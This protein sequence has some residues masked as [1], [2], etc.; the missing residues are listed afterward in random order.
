MAAAVRAALIEALPD[1][2]DSGPAELEHATT[3][4]QLHARA[5]ALGLDFHAAVRAVAGSDDTTTTATEEGKTMPGENNTGDG[6]V[7]AFRTALAKGEA[8][9]M[10]KGMEAER[11]RIAAVDRPI[12]RAARPCPVRTR[13]P[14]I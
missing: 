6:D 1:D 14:V 5:D 7:V 10:S 3:I 4:D 8:Q 9:G 2:V 12:M 13:A 11:T